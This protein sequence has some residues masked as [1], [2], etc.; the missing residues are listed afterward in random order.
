MPNDPTDFSSFEQ[1][2]A[3]AAKPRPRAGIRFWRQADVDPVKTAEAGRPVTRDVDYVG[4]SNPGS[5]DEHVKAIRANDA[6]FMDEYGDLY[7]KWKETLEQPAD[8]T[9]LEMVPFLTPSE[10]AELKYYNVRSLEQL[11]SVSDQGLSKMGP[12]FR[13]KRDQAIAYMKNAQDSSS[14]TRLASENVLLRQRIGDLE[15]EVRRIGALAAA[16]PAPAAVPNGGP[17]AGVMAAIAAMQAELAS[18]KRGPGR[19]RKEAPE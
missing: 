10:I 4:I 13:Q 6:K 3:Q 15:A 2:F 7:R 12:G 14:A 5:R 16:H 11:G 9:A 18:L 19:P 8:G 17:D 1:A